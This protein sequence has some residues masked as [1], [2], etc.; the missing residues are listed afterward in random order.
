MLHLSD[1]GRTT[2]YYLE[3]FSIILLGVVAYFG[4][5]FGS[6]ILDN[7]HCTGNEVSLFSCPHNGIKKHNCVHREDAG[8]VCGSG[9][10]LRMSI[11]HQ[12]LF[13]NALFMLILNLK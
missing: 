7:L 3:S 5:G 9:K 1:N 10:L 6:I 11:N 12:C 13:V 8:V 4:T 2:L